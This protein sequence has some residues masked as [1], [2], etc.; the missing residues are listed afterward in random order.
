MQEGHTG[1]ALSKGSNKEAWSMKHS[2][3]WVHAVALLVAGKCCS[4]WLLQAFA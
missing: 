1:K 4:P 2:G 3:M